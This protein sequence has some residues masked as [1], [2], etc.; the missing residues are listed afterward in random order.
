MIPQVATSSASTSPTA[1]SLWRSGRGILFV[2]LLVVVAAVVPLLLSS[3]ETQGQPLDPADSSHSG[4]RALAQLLGRHGVTV[5]RV[6]SVSVALAESGANSQILV[7]DASPLSGEEAKQ[8]A[9]SGT[10]RLIVGTMPYLTVLAPGVTV[11]ETVRARSRA[12]ACPLRQATRAGGAHMGGSAF[13]GPA[14]SVGCYP[15]GKGPTLVRYV[16]GGHTVTVVGDSAFMTNLRLADD[17][18]A[19]LAL[20]LAGA[21]P[22]LIWLVAP[23]EGDT[24]TGVPGG[25]GTE[26]LGDLIPSQ[27]NWAV[28]QLLIALM[29]VA[30]W[31]GRRLGP[32]VA[33]RLPVAVRAAETVEGRGR[34]YRAHRARDRAALAL[35]HAAVGR[36]TPRLGLAGAATPDQIVA[37][38]AVRTGQE[39]DR[40]RSALF[41]AAPADDAAL[42]ALAGYL[43]TLERQVRDS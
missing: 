36:M 15:A 38:T 10:D 28:L 16:S 14:G 25:S 42:V 3:S 5:E 30:F 7:S 20:N 35:R 19:A 4:G 27:V 29:V 8:L 40:V 33:E 23:E 6:E 12:P 43:D 13:A 39:A 21:K 41:G 11:T 1:R 32:V 24:G 18:N 26:T 22:R 2:A 34:L 31:R 9:A 17:G 37:A